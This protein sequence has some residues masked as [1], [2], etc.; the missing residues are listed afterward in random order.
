VASARI[1]QVRRQTLTCLLLA[2]AVVIAPLFLYLPLWLGLVWLLSVI[3]RVQVHRGAWHYPGNLKKVMMALLTV[4]GLLWQYGLSVGVEPM[5]GLLL[6]AFMLKLV[7]ARQRRD[8][9]LIIFI[10][11]VAVSGQFLFS[12]TIF[13]FVYGAFSCAALLIAWYSCFATRELRVRDYIQSRLP[14]QFRR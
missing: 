5:V 11:F 7:E 13:A 9:L 8:L 14:R 3:I 4:G 12:Q 10:G 1:E 6:A 2:Q